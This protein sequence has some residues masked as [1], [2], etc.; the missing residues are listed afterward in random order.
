MSLD[1]LSYAV[2]QGLDN[3]SH[4]LDAKPYRWPMLLLSIGLSI[5]GLTL[6]P[7]TL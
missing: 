4:W 6:L 5:Y 3:I 7:E 2:M 1:E